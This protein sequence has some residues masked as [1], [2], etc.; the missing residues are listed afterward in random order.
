MANITQWLTVIA[1][2]ITGG[3]F[4]TMATQLLK[5]PS[6]PSWA[7][8]ALAIGVS[9]VVGL[10]S[11]WLAGGLTSFISSWGHLSAAQILAVCALIYTAAA[12]WFHRVYGSTTWFAALAWW[13]NKAP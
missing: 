2:V 6:W 9:A 12:T 3:W 11:V 5:R 8:L 1:V 13:P 4:A 7:K 10:A